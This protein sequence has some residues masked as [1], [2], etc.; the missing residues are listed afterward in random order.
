MKN[1]FTVACM[2]ALSATQ[3]A[4]DKCYALAFGAGEQNSA[5]T[6]GA[7]QGLIESYGAE[8]TAYTAVSG[9]SGGGVNAAI[10]GSFGVGQEA[11][12]VARMKSFWENTSNS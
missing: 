5:Y 6:A 2:L 1:T 10:L 8:G 4:A 12:A 3:V 11:E 7:L 9:I